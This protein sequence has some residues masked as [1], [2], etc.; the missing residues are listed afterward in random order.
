MTSAILMLF[1]AALASLNLGQWVSVKYCLDYDH[2]CDFNN[3]KTWPLANN[4][5]NLDREYKP[6]TND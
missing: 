5:Y 6:V 1:L 2:S 4:Q 3:T